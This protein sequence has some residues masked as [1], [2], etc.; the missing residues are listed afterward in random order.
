[1]PSIASPAFTNEYI[2]GLQKDKWAELVA[3]Y[4][5]ARLRKHK[6]EWREQDWL[7]LYTYP[8]VVHIT[9]IWEEWASGLHG[10]LSTRQLEERWGAKWRR[11]LPQMK[12]PHSRRKKVVSL[13]LALSSKQGWDTAL[14]L[15]FLRE[16]YEPQFTAR[17]F[18]EY[19]QK[20]DGSGWQA[21]LAATVLYM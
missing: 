13:V 5:E 11:N 18:C 16:R 7:P 20:K 14:A 19:L 8:E 9:E 10:H 3:A 12:T 21:V 1:M 17:K 15:R 2:M 6:W 4:P